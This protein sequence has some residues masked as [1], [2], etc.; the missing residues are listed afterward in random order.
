M[1]IG[2]FIEQ[3]I[4][5]KTNFKGTNF[6]IQSHMLERSKSEYKFYDMYLRPEEK[7]NVRD[8][9]YVQFVEGTLKSR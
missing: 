9:L 8:V 6:V 4:P 3:L 5:R 2:T 1:S 7:Q